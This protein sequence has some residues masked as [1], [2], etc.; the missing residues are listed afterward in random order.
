MRKNTRQS[1]ILLSIF[2]ALVALPAHTA[3]ADMGPKPSMAFAF[4]FGDESDLA[5]SGGELMQCQDASCEVAEP[6][7]ELG[8]QGFNC[9]ADSCSAMAYGFSEWGY[10]RITFSDGSTRQSNIFGKEHFDAEYMV[11]VLADGLQVEE[12]GGRVN[13]MY[14]IIGAA[15]TGS[16]CVGMAA[17]YLGGFYI[18]LAWREGKKTMPF[19]EHKLQYIAAWVLA[20]LL[21]IAGGFF[22]LA[23]PLTAVLELVVAWLY[24]RWRDKPKAAMLTV[25]LIVNVLTQFILLGVFSNFFGDR[26]WSA[27]LLMEL[28]IWQGEAALMYLPRRKHFTFFEVVWMSLAMNAV[29]YLVGLLLPF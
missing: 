2:V 19:E 13:P 26:Y 9:E 7:E 8:P 17:M 10:L 5:I 12:T 25:V 28:F 22:S 4:D 15:I 3:R 24:L 23:V 20:G 1:L 16:I 27:L 11:T 18:L 14:K 29:S 21:A 6:L